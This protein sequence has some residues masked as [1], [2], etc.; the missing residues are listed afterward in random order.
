MVA[1]YAAI[2][3]LTHDEVCR[4][5]EGKQTVDFKH[6]LGQLLVE[7]LAPIREKAEQL[8]SDPA[9]VDGI[10]MEGAEKARKIAQENIAIIKTKMGIC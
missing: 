6:S 3:G 5:F 1:I 2:S 8:E 7:A 4:E 10:L 9:H